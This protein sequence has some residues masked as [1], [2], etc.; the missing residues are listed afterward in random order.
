MYSVEQAF[1]GCVGAWIYSVGH[2]V[3]AHQGARAQRLENYRLSMFARCGKG[4]NEKCEPRDWMMDNKARDDF[5][6]DR[7]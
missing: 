7:L 3:G 1:R 4:K 6:S 5:V 2:Q